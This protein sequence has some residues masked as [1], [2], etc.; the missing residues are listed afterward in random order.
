MDRGGESISR[1]PVLVS[2]LFQGVLRNW[3]STWSPAW[4]SATAA[5]EVLQEAMDRRDRLLLADALH[6]ALHRGVGLVHVWVL[7]ALLTSSWH[8]DHRRL[9]TLVGQLPGAA[10]ADVLLGIVRSYTSPSG[11]SDVARCT[12]SAA[13]ATLGALPEAHSRPALT[14]LTTS[15]EQFVRDEAREALG[16]RLE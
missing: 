4:A 5:L 1:I 2:G 7:S 12:L 16:L 15:R 11:F 6:V 14:S 10:T 13:I 9:A 3:L 8:D